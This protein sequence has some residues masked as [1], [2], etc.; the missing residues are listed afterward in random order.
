MKQGDH[1]ARTLASET[2]QLWYFWKNKKSHNIVMTCYLKK[3]TN[4]FYPKGN[5][6]TYF[7]RGKFHFYT[8]KKVQLHSRKVKGK[9]GHI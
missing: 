7:W 3:L 9:L 5:N 6:F 8:H 1:K 4:K 2:A